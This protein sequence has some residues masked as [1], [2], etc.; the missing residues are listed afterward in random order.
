[1]TEKTVVTSYLQVYQ[2]W[3]KARSRAMGKLLI[4]PLKSIEEIDFATALKK[5]FDWALANG[6]TI[7]ELSQ[8]CESGRNDYFDELISTFHRNHV[9]IVISLKH[10]GNS[11][12]HG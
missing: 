4:F 12:T 5:E 10:V 3:C 11:P 1:M 8:L 7:T 2:D 9:K 6:Y